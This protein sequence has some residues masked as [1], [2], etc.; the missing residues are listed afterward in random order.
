MII[1]IP[2]DIAPMKRRELLETLPIK[3]GL[4]KFKTTKEIAAFL[5]FSDRY[6]RNKINE[7]DYLS[8]IRY[9]D[10]DYYDTNLWGNYE[11]Y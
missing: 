10:R 1:E 8:A 5:G 6:I 2:D 11:K 3:Y 9:K 7:H 4:E